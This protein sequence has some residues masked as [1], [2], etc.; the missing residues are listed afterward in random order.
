MKIKILIG[1]AVVLLIFSYIAISS[2]TDTSIK[3]EKGKNNFTFNITEPF[4]AETLV[5][6]NPEIEVISH[7]EGDKTIGY[8][9][10]YE[11]IGRNFIIKQ[12]E[13]YEIIVEKDINLVL[14]SNDL[15]NEEK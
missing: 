11:G 7:K 9:N 3:L 6:L 2:I 8:V 1:V 5:K 10:V 4:Y 14:P 12:G 15:E 13:A